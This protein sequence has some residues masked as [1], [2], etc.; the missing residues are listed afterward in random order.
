MNPV[1]RLAVYCLMMFASVFL[2]LS[3]VELG[4]ML[5]ALR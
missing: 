1:A 2:T 3:A 4:L 5:W